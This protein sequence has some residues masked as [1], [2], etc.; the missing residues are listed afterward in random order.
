MGMTSM[1]IAAP[2][3]EADI[4]AWVIAILSVMTVAM[5]AL[6]LLRVMA[7][8]R[9]PQVV[10]NDVK[11]DK[12]VP[13]EAAA[14]L[15]LQ[16][17]DTV[18][19]A[20]HRQDDT[21]RRAEM[22]TLKGDI[23]ARL[24]TVRGYTAVKTI[25]P[26]LDRTTRN[27]MST[28]SA[29]LRAAGPKEAEGLAALAEFAIPA[30][31][32]WS[33]RTFPTIRGDGDDVR[34]G[35]SVEVA[36]LGH[37]PDAITT[38]WT[39]SDALQKPPSE[40][41]RL[42]I[43]RELLH[44]L[45]RPAS[46]W[47]AVQLVSHHLTQKRSRYHGLPTRG[48][49]TELA[50]LQLQL[51]GQLLLYASREQEKFVDGFA[52]KALENLGQ[53]AELLPHYYRPWSTQGAVYE[54]LGWSCRHSGDDLRAQRTFTRS[55]DTYDKAEE[56]LK[57]CSQADQNMRD[58]LIQRLALRRTKC[59][60]LSCDHEAIN[61]A[62]KELSR[63]SE[64]KDKSPL[65]FYNAACLFTVA[66]ACP[67]ISGDKRILYKREAWH[68][69]GLALVFSPPRAELWSRMMTDEELGALDMHSR[70]KFGDEIKKRCSRRSKQGYLEADKQP[71]ADRIVKAAITALGLI[72]P[73]I[74]AVV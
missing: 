54:R 20:L 9:R 31:C 44:E 43:I 50:G 74:R 26:E 49:S 40:A 64:L 68:Y 69:L 45:V 15:S 25:V 4:T 52:Y 11:P 41:A 24:L 33:V 42:T 59:R 7:E 23:A 29:G 12:G 65:S 67:N 22:G 10:I 35:L 57:A 14:G 60:L 32:G 1:L 62:S 71:E 3:I 16:L 8:R 46:I 37:A 30:Q 51:G 53:A 70:K 18:R 19:R 36:Q 28:L 2:R 55:V 21:A 56:L 48:S 63:Y 6:G 61:I 39:T 5:I 66:M 47:I 13:V 38:F 17:R 73:S 27:S 72:S 58:A 34:V